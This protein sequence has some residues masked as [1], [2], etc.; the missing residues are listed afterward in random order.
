MAMWVIT[1]WYIYGLHG[2][3]KLKIH[4]TRAPG[5]DPAFP[6]L[7]LKTPCTAN[8]GIWISQSLPTTVNIEKAIEN[9]GLWWLY[10]D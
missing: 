5:L 6:G 7:G 9:N 2:G 4:I 1:R 3:D 8:H 10:G